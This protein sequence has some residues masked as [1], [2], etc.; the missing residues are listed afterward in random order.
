MT[1]QELIYYLEGQNQIPP[2]P[3]IK[4][5]TRDEI[6]T[7]RS[8]LQGVTVITK[9]YGTF[10]AF[11]PEI[12]MLDYPED[13]ISYYEATK[14]RGGKVL[15]I[16][17]A[18]FTYSEPPFT[19]PVPGPAYRWVND[20]EGFC[21]RL[22]E[23]LVVGKFTGI[24]LELPG[25]GQTGVDGNPFGY[26]WLMSNLDPLI[27]A[28][29]NYP[30]RDLTKWIIFNPGFDGVVWNWSAEQVL[31]F[32]N[33]MRGSLPNCYLEI[34]YG[35]GIIGPFG[36]GKEQ[37]LRA[38]TVF[39]G[40]A[41]ESAYPPESNLDQIFQIGARLL[42]PKYNRPSNNK[43]QFAPYYQDPN[44]DPGAPFAAGSS[45]DYLSN[46]TPRGKYYTRMREFLTYGYVRGW[47][48]DATVDYWV[49]YFR[50]IG[51]GEGVG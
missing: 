19:F 49:N 2:T 30:E 39:D 40:F 20:L 12:N 10:K 6:F 27:R 26:Q 41:Q 7:C 16:G 5:P 15:N 43:P 48:T 44:D 42:G 25:D 23:I 29:V 24:L 31:N 32:A 11:G 1:A 33:K 4:E 21:A 45:N 47:V 13:R 18:G 50:N 22:N 38:L 14:L 28:L 3:P 8:L 35:A 9:Q 37:Y 34:E 46:G 51:W 17:W 36:E